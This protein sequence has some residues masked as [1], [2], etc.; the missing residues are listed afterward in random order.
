[1]FLVDVQLDFV[2]WINLAEDTKQW[3]AFFKHSNERFGSV[4]GEKFPDN[5]SNR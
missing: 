5:L 4:K 3:L 1:M 2:E